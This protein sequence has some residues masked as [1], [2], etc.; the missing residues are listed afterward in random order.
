ME[1]SEKLFLYQKIFTNGEMCLPIGEIYQVAELSIVAGGVISPHIQR[2]DEITYVISGKAKICSDSTIEEVTAGKIH[3][4]KKGCEHTI[5]ADNSG[6]LHYM[7]VGFIPNIENE[8]YSDFIKNTKDMG[9]FVVDDNGD[10]RKIL[11]LAMDE[12]Y[13]MDTNSP[14]MMNMYLSQILIFFNRI[15]IGGK[16]KEKKQPLQCNLRICSRTKLT[17]LLTVLNQERNLHRI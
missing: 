6:K 9:G 7:C 15:L 3:Y 5:I 1:F 4:T 17:D 14:A 12:I 11:E 10:V 8:V 13:I 16:E 2:C